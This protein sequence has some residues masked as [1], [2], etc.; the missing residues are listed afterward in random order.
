MN[1][2][3]HFLIQKSIPVKFRRTALAHLQLSHDTAH[4]RDEAI[5]F[6]PPFV[7]LRILKF[8]Y[9]DTISKTA[10]VTGCCDQ[11]IDQLVGSV[12]VEIYF[13]NSFI[14][15]EGDD[16]IAFYFIV[17]G[18]AEEARTS[19]AHGRVI[20]VLEEGDVFGEASLMCE[21]PQPWSVRTT[22]TT[23]RLIAISSRSWRALAEKFPEEQRRCQQ[24]ILKTFGSVNDPVIHSTVELVKQAIARND[25][26][27]A[28]MMS[29]AAARGSA[30]EVQHM[31][32]HFE[33]PPD[34]ADYDYRTALHLAAAHGHYQVCKL[35][36]DHGANVN[37]RDRFGYTPLQEA[38]NNDH[39]GVAQLLKQS[40]G[41]LILNDEAG[42]LCRCAH[43]SNSARLRS[44]LFCGAD[45]NA[46]NYDGRTALHVACAE[47]NAYIAR[48][49]L[50]SGADRNAKDRWGHTPLREAESGG[51]QKVA[52]LFSKPLSALAKEIE[53]EGSL[54]DQPHVHWET[55]GDGTVHLRPG[56]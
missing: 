32:Q 8:L 18:S 50:V 12:D 39:I 53:Q 3:N 6:C 49:L 31:L 9:K 21:I 30:A 42:V 16:P 27:Q 36:L 44:L 37:V 10:L 11:F 47:G 45:P 14:L 43:T 17:S 5:Q 24:N 2:L 7:K 51:H 29:Y 20:R 26:D 33:Y 56:H 35:L 4:E 46:A 55:G 23:T 25:K 48:L 1:A 38:M 34:R 19:V 40:G 13:P 15:S 54:Q 22:I 52:T 28:S 41:L